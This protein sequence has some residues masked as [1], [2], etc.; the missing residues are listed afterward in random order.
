M[1][2]MQLRMISAA[3]KRISFFE[4]LSIA[5]NATHWKRGMNRRIS[6]P[7]TTAQKKRTD[8]HIKGIFKVVSPSDRLIGYL[9]ALR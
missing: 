7:M 9:L 4:A 5:P 1:G 3:A 6:P 2:T 8:D